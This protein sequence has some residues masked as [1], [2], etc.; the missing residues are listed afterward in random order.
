[1]F[2]HYVTG[3]IISFHDFCR[4]IFLH[5]V[6][7]KRYRVL[8]GAVGRCAG[9]HDDPGVVLMHLEKKLRIVASFCANIPQRFDWATK[10]FGG[11]TV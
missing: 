9:L 6:E 1:M 7:N 5:F 4:F 11:I 8:S 3:I 2:M 10:S